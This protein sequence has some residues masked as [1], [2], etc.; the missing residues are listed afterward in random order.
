MKN[1]LTHIV[2]YEKTIFD[3]K[4]FEKVRHDV[5][6]LRKKPSNILRSK[7]ACGLKIYVKEYF[8]M[9]LSIMK[10]IVQAQSK[11]NHWI[12]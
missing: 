8:Y 3:K 7:K 12:S 1:S 9:F 6:Q 4:V 11:A 10:I 5:R 2:N